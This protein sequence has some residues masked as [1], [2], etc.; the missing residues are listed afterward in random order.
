MPPMTC[1]RATDLRFCSNLYNFP[2]NK[3]VEAAEPVNPKISQPPP[4][5]ARRPHGKG[6]T[7]SVDPSQAKCELG[8]R[9]KNYKLV[10]GDILKIILPLFAGN[11]TPN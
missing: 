4:A 7:G 9:H 1:L 10:F 8:M 3:I 6:D 2:L 5:S 11:R